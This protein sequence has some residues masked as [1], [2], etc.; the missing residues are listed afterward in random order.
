MLIPMADLQVGDVIRVRTGSV[1]PVDGT[2]VSG[3]AN[4]NEASM[5]G[6][7]LSVRKAEGS[8][9]FAGTVVDEGMIA[10]QVDALSGNTKI[11][12]SSS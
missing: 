3:E 8:T 4:I 6:E 11:R 9:V 12:R 5:T 1:I 10:V 2:V 7:P